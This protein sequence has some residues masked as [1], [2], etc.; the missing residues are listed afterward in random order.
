MKK[1]LAIC[2]L[3][4]IFSCIGIL[5]WYTEWRYSL[6]TPVPERYFAVKLNERINVSGQLASSKNRPVFLHFF[7][8][9]CPCSRFNIPHFKSLVAQYAGKVSFAVVV[10]TKDKNYTEQKIKEK[11]DLTM[12]VLFDTS[13]AVLCGVYSTP[14]AVLLN[15]DHTLYYRGN[16]N[17]SRYCTDKKS[18][19]A[20]MAIDSLLADKHGL[21]FNKYALTAYGCSLPSCKK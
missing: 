15:N 1:W 17:R 7:N 16:Y 6:P 4:L 5:F 13:L 21:A 9:D 18:N 8:P 11:F 19:Y 20:Q 2:C 3:I 12:P 10:M 14:Q